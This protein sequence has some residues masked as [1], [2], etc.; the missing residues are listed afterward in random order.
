MHLMSVVQG[1]IGPESS[2]P[3]LDARSADKELESRNADSVRWEKRFLR[4]VT[5]VLK[6]DQVGEARY[7][8]ETYLARQRQ[9][10]EGPK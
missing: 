1:W 10:T 3:A 4:F 9:R 2:W 8:L 6:L 7:I 5:D